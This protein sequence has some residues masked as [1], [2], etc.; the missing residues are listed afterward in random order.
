MRPN[1]ATAFSDHVLRAMRAGRSVP[2]VGARIVRAIAL[3]LA[4]PIAIATILIFLLTAAGAAF[5]LLIARLRRNP[6]SDGRAG[7][8]VI[9]GEYTVV[10]EPRGDDAGHAR[11]RHTTLTQA[12]TVL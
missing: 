7:P 12:G 9:D 3:L 4:I 1:R 6:P 8:V 10:P 11:R 5:L 2:P